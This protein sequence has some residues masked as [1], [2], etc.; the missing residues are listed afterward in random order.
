MTQVGQQAPSVVGG[1]QTSG[2]ALQ[3]LAF[4]GDG[5]GLVTVDARQDAGAAFLHLCDFLC[6]IA[7]PAP[8]C[9]VLRCR[10][11]SVRAWV[12]CFCMC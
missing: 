8:R 7:A 1:R 6:L 9:G 12:P 4:S 10:A 2:A 11:C 3:H 5:A